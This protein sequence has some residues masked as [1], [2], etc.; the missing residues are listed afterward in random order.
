MNTL[1]EAALES[2]A[3]RAAKHAG[4]IARKSRWRLGSV[5]NFGQ[6]RLVDRYGNYVVAGERFDLSA[7]EVIE[8]C[9]EDKVS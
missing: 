3:R 9:R 7:E 4:L 2:R 8:Y 5:D 1:S 6:F